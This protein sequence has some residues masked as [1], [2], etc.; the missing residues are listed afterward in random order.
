MRKEIANEVINLNS[1]IE[2]IRKTL[3]QSYLRRL[4]LEL[5]LNDIKRAVLDLSED[6]EDEATLDMLK[7][8]KEQAEEL[9]NRAGV[10]L[11]WYL[12]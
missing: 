1:F 11:P 12:Y 5:K 4:E 2:E 6:D 3:P 8:Y 9:A 7:A 10:N